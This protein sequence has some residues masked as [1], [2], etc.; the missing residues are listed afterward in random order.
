MALYIVLVKA[1]RLLEASTR[2]S[3]ISGYVRFLKSTLF[4]DLFLFLFLFL[5][6]YFLT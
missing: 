1:A 3:T 2:S 4:L 5:N 6:F